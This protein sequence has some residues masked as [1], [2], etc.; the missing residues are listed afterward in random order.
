[1]G[2]IKKLLVG[3][4][5]VGSMVVA[6]LAI[7]TSA[8]AAEC[9]AVGPEK[10]EL[11]QDVNPL[12]CRYVTGIE[13]QEVSYSSEGC[14]LAVDK[15]VSINGGPFVEADTSADAA[16]AHVGDTVTWKITVSNPNSEDSSGQPFGL[17]RVNDVLPSA[18]VSYDGSS[19][20]ASSGNYSG[21]VW[22]FVLYDTSPPA[23]TNLPA[24]LTITTTATAT[25]LF[26]NI[27]TLS[28]Y[29]PCTSENNCGWEGGYQDADSSNDSNDAW[30]DPSAQ[31]VV[32]ADTTLTNTGSGTTASIIA[33]G[34]IGTTLLVTL[35]NR[36][37]RSKNI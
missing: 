36:P 6:P 1:M 15:T 19:Y 3:F 30:I 28:D 27:A 14:D 20:T 33:A 24:T 12:L 2:S 8:H 7:A 25:G 13:F 31:P 22:E 34:L 18:G 5:Y 37:S 29:N 32:L 35:V 4:A 9:D 11:S 10:C 26:Q 23:H 17:V 21:N 16:Q